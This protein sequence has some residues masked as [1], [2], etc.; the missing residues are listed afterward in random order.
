ML[1]SRG[2][3]A[4]IGLIATGAA[5]AAGAPVA[6]AFCRGGAVYQVSGAQATVKLTGHSLDPVSGALGDAVV[7]G[8]AAV[9]SR[10]IRWPESYGLAVPQGPRCNR[11]GWD[12]YV[13]ISPI[14]F[15]MNGSWYVPPPDSN[16]QPDQGTCADMT[17]AGFLVVQYV[18]GADIVGAGGRERAVLGPDPSGG[19]SRFLKC[20]G[21]AGIGGSLL[22]LDEIVNPIN[23]PKGDIRT[24]LA[25]PVRQLLHQTSRVRLSVSL[26]F[27]QP[28]RYNPEQGETITASFQA[29]VRM[30]LRYKCT[31]ICTPPGQA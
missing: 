9:G 17:R 13:K 19:T 23:N 4:V 11:L 3:A 15:T 16:S 29:T 7:Q 30:A 28:A 8:H 25:V 2:L 20:D 21:L 18:P 10:Q 26:S 22:S 31:I 6:S 1:C 24:T 14:P 12:F 5:V 27:V